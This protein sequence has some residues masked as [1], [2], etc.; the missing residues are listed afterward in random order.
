MG[1]G[2]GTGEAVGR[3]RTDQ[4][5]QNQILTVMISHQGR[6]RKAVHGVDGRV[7]KRVGLSAERHRA[8]PRAVATAVPFSWDLRLTGV[9]LS[10]KAAEVSFVV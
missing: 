2:G 8:V 10:Q 9:S 3:S 6:G 4:D 5:G 1:R 7:K